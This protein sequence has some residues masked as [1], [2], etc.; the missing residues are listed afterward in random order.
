MSKDTSILDSIRLPQQIS[1]YCMNT[2]II[3]KF[4]NILINYDI[5]LRAKA[6]IDRNDNVEQMKEETSIIKGKCKNKNTFDDSSNNAIRERIKL[7]VDVGC[8]NKCRVCRHYS[9]LN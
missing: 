6:S 1:S 7:I 5:W 4:L 3:K 9:K 2:I 8:Q